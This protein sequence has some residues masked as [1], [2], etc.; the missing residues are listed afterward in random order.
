MLVCYIHL[1]KK[2]RTD[3]SFTVPKCHFHFIAS[4]DIEAQKACISLKQKYGSDS[5]SRATTLIVL[6]GDGT[7]LTT[8]RKISLYYKKNQFAP[9]KTVYGMNFGT[10]GA[11][12]N[13]YKLE[14]LPERINCAQ[15]FIFKPLSVQI[16]REN[17]DILE[18]VAFNEVTMSRSS[19]Q[20]P[21]I[22]ISVN[23]KC[24]ETI[25][26]DT[27]ICST[28]QGS[29]AYYSA[30]GGSIIPMDSHLLGLQSVCA[31]QPKDNVLKPYHF[32]QLIPDNV[33]VSFK[34]ISSDKHRLVQV[35]CDRR[36]FKHV[37]A[38]RIR[39]NNT[40]SVLVM[41]EKQNQIY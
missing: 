26:G 22:Q 9:I 41:K 5:F 30:A 24:V 2:N 13:P 1:M 35:S 18:D 23:E 40:L 21:K 25:K 32:N 16:E 34:N 15:T 39:Q 20:V 7:L 11:W 28:P 6:G 33:S 19:T 27:I 8:L 36:V 12:M 10:L 38:V 3:V 17:K 4:S 14:H 29:R 31:Y 37:I